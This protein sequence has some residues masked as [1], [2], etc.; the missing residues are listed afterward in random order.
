MA[1]GYSVAVSSKTKPPTME[2]MIGSLSNFIIYFP[3]SL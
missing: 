2:Y 3:N 1:M